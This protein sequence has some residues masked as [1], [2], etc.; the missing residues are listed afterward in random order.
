MDAMVI[1]VVFS[2]PSD[3]VSS[4][5][6]ND[7]TGDP[8]RRLKRAINDQSA[9]QQKGLFDHLVSAKYH[10]CWQLDAECFRRLPVDDELAFDWS[11]DR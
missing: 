11:L 7:Q 2:T 4:Y 9:L 1:R 5:P 3:H 8:L 6:D 10:R